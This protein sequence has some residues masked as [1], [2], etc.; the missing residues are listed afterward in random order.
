MQLEIINIDHALG[1]G[2][3]T[4][5]PDYEG[6][7]SAFTVGPLAGTGVLDGIRAAL[8]FQTVIPNKTDTQLAMLGYSGGGLGE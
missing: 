7:S 8:N 3:I 1:S 5:V 4:L 2:Y 6:L